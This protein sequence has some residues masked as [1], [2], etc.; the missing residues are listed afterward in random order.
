[1]LGNSSSCR[2]RNRKKVEERNR[3]R[4]KIRKNKRVGRRK[5]EVKWRRWRKF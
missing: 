5:R 3:V 2:K 4:R 1:M